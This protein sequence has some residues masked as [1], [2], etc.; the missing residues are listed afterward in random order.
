MGLIM[1]EKMTQCLATVF[2]I[3]TLWL[4]GIIAEPGSQLLAGIGMGICAAIT[5]ELILAAARRA[6]P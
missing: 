4:A 2:L 1:N 5:V 3:L 6:K